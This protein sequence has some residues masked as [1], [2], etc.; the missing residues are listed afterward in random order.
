MA[1][2][3]LA[4][5]LEPSFCSTNTSS[6]NSI[7]PSR[8]WELAP[9]VRPGKREEI[10]DDYVLFDV[11]K[12]AATNTFTCAVQDQEREMRRLSAAQR[13]NQVPQ[14]VEIGLDIDHFT[15]N[16][17]GDCYQ[18]IDWALGVLAGVDLVYRT[19]STT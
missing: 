17:F 10:V 6:L 8:Q 9:A 2:D 5:S 19:N 12:S 18:A 1:N 7:A 4:K 13:G 15:F 3:K 11:A 14:C 16:T